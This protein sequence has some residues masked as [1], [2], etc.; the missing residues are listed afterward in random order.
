MSSLVYLWVL[1]VLLLLLNVE[2]F[3]YYDFFVLMEQYYNKISLQLSHNILEMT[4]CEVMLK[5]V[6]CYTTRPLQ[7]CKTLL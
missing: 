6:M 1:H 4:E 7:L 3:Q 2:Q 5:D